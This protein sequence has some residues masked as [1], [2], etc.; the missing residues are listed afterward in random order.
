MKCGILSAEYGWHIQEL[1]RALDKFQVEHRW[2]SVLHL[3]SRINLAPRF[4]SKK[5]PIDDCD[6]IFVRIIPLGSLE[7]IVFRM[8]TLHH[9]KEEGKR[10]VNPPDCIEKLVDKY[11]T[12]ALLQKHGIPTPRTVVT[13]NLD[14]AMAAFDL[15]GDVLVKPIFG[16]IGMGIVRVSERDL[17]YRTFKALDIQRAVHYVQEFLPTGN[18]DVRLFVVNEEVVTS[19][20]RKGD[21]WKT[22]FYGGGRVEP[23]EPKEDEIDLALRAAKAVGA[24]YTGVD[25]IRPEGGSPYVIELNAI[26]G[27][28][29]VQQVTP[30][31][32]AERIV[33]PL[34]TR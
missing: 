17:A 28:R 13:E 22:N 1:E 3:V 20:K 24:Y 31:N 30:F 32:L 33:G 19:M 12:S 14:E 26:P 2:Y 21:T 5:S 23:Y 9:M 6:L 15:F 8:D 11:Y 16:S 27:W 7:Q 4:E 18:E 29:G 34:V 10:V 25:V